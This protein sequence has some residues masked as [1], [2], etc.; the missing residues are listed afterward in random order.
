MCHTKFED[1]IETNNFAFL[2]FFRISY[3]MVEK[4]NYRFSIIFFK[5]KKK[6]ISIY[7]MKSI[8]IQICRS[9]YSD[10]FC[11]ITLFLY[12]L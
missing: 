3:I 10:Q 4:L 11:I 5:I 9:L 2:R 8:A 7:L 6:N 12:F 1:H